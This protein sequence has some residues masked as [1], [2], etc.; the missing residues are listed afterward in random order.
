MGANYKLVL[1]TPAGVKLGEIRNF[2]YLDC[3]IAVNRPGLLK[4]AIP[5]SNQL[6][7]Q[8]THK[9]QV[10]MWR[11]YPDYDIPW[12]CQFRGFYLAQKR[13][14]QSAKTTFTMACPGQMWLLGTRDVLWFAGT[15][16]RSKFITEAGETIMKTM[17]YRNAG[18][19]ALAVDGRRRN[20]AITGIGIEADAGRGEVLDWYC[21]WDNLLESLQNLALVA[22]GDYDLVRTGG[23]TWEFR[24]YLGQLGTDRTS[25]LKFSVEGGNLVDP[26]YEYDRISDPTVAIVGGKR[27]G[28]ARE[29]TIVTSPYYAAD[30]DVE[31]FVNATNTDTED[32]RTDEGMQKL[33]AARAREKFTFNV[34]QT[35]KCL[36]GQDYFLGDLGRVVNP[37]TGTT[38]TQ[39]IGAVSFS[40]MHNMPE[41]IGETLVTP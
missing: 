23:A 21:A 33:E 34:R 29:V 4:A 37:F 18:A 5:G 20:G 15:N 31:M 24:F 35:P 28:S 32:G 26:I 8:L 12:T 41:T 1:R 39:K 27:A 19:G 30:N 11:S 17:V 9:S 22:G 14:M 10:E 13:Q 2:S 36:Y 40:K 7:S 3:K 38:V 6:V 25:S 16:N